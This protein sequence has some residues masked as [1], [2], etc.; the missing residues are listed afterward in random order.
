MAAAIIPRGSRFIAGGAISPSL[1]KVDGPTDGLR[2]V[3]L[4]DL[5][6]LIREAGPKFAGK[7]GN[8]RDDSRSAKALR[9]GA[10]L[11]ASGASYE[12]MRDALLEHEDPDIA[13][14]A[15]TKGLANGER[16][17]RRIFDKAPR[18]CRRHRY[19]R[20][21]RHGAAVPGRP[22]HPAALSPGQLL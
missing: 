8:G 6:W 15:R 22:R 1:R 5:Q 7:S 20:A 16:E 21:L 14:W 4:A 18:R 9:A 10:A 19:S 2:R 13:E 11:K 17:L 12:A 3:D